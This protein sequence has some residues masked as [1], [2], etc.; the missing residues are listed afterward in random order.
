MYAMAYRSV[1]YGFGPVELAF[2]RMD[3]PQETMGQRITQLIGA[4][5]LTQSKLAR[6]LGCSRM[7]VSQWARDVSDPRPPA[8]LKLAKVLGT[9]PAYLVFGPKREPPGGFPSAERGTR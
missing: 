3:A 6:L 9:D 5:G 1:N 2:L 4:R 7:T 8:L